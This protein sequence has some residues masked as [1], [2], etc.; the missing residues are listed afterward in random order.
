MGRVDNDRIKSLLLNAADVLVHAS[1][2]EVF[3]Q[4]LIEAM[5]CGTPSLAFRVGGI[6]EIITPGE[7]GWLVDQC[8]ADALAVAID[9]AIDKVD[10]GIQIRAACRQNAVERFDSRLMT[11]RYVDLF[12]TTMAAHAASVASSQQPTVTSRSI[13]A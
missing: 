11:S 10:H 5:A 9:N 13:I 8:S 3:G 4:V 12:Q 6:P 2:A 7:T 1:R